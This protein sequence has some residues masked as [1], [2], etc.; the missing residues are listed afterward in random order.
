MLSVTF[1]KAGYQVE[2]A[3][4]GQEAWDKLSNGLSCD[5]LLC[6]IEMPRMN[7]LELLAKMQQDDDLSQLPVAMLT[8]RGAQKHRK[9]A[10]DLGA[11]AYFTKPYLEEEL[12][13]AAKLL[14]QGEVL[15]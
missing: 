10:A 3:R 6:D 13:K 1:Q 2:Q 11:K 4:D 7:G 9:I 8:S 5:L 15:L 12:L 14:I